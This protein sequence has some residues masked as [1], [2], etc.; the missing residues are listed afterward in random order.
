[1]DI[2][3]FPIISA[4]VE[5]AKVAI[6]NAECGAKVLVVRN[7]VTSAVATIQALETL[8]ERSS[9]VLFR[10]KR[11]TG[12]FVPTLHH[13]RFGPEDRRVLDTTV[14]QQIGRDRPTGGLIVIGTQ[15]LEQSLDLDADLLLTDLCPVDV[16]L[17]R[18]GRLHRHDR[19][20]PA[21]FKTPRAIVLTPTERDLLVGR[22]SRFGLGMGRTGGVYEDLRIVELTWRLI[23]MHRTWTI[24]AMNRRLVEMATH[25][26][27]LAVVELELSQQTSAWAEHF[28]KGD[29]KTFAAIT[30]A[31]SA[32]L[33]RHKQFDQFQIDTDERLG[34]RLGARDRLVT[35]ESRP[36]GP[37]GLSVSSL[38]IPHHLL[39]NVPEAALALG[40]VQMQEGFS[41]QLGHQM[42]N[43]TRFGLVRGSGP[44]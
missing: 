7:T 15:T 28:T 3:S 16:L 8:V 21:G 43:Y 34:T 6:K 11:S 39:G 44:Q 36:V 22:L 1:V 26:E 2:A 4:P 24:P 9:S 19:V 30:A 32:L 25:P 23:E 5:V 17:Q 41:F 20:R 38:R 37:F 29:G 35:L 12:G 33:D 31:A 14:Q 13:S 18:I 27:S 42:F 40:I 10:V